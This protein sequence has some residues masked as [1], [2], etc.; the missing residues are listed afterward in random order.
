MTGRGL[1]FWPFRFSALS[2]LWGGGFFA[3]GRLP[4][5]STAL[6]SSYEEE[7]AFLR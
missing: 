1:F 2:P 4:S 6:S 3:F 5:A 7:G